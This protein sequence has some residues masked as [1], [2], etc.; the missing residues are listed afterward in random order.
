MAA[1][2]W[3]GNGELDWPQSSSPVESASPPPPLFAASTTPT[4]STYKLTMKSGLFN[5]FRGVEM[6]QVGCSH[7]T[8]NLSSR[9]KSIWAL[10]RKNG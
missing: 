6:G 1:P 8:K 7:V 10:V 2:P 4:E 9:Y 5:Q 3:S